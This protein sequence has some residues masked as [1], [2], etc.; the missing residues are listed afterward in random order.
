MVKAFTLYE[1]LGVERDATE[2]QIRSAFRKLTFKHHPD[3]F[4]G[5]E[6][7]RAEERFQ[8]LTEAFNVLS[9]PQSRAKYDEELA[10]GQPGAGAA[11]DRRE[12]AR[13]LAAKGSQTLKE[14][15][16]S[17]ALSELK[18]ALDH[19]DNCARA[20]YFMGVALGKVD[21]R[22]RDSLRHLE[23]ALSLEPANPAMMAETAVAAMRIGMKERAQRL[24]EQ[25]MGFDPTNQK[26]AKVLRQ[27]EES[28]SAPAAGEGFF[29]RLRRKG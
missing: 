1:T 26:A 14:G 27:I 11:M 6:R 20:H 16:L 17:Q 21:G 28:D 10:Q 23:R 24:A 13:R 7:E 2:A 4:T 22:E 5:E 9:R 8:E 3:R 18:S 12:I 15:N 19:D 25:A 29:G